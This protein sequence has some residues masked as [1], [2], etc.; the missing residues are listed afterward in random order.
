M[1]LLRENGYILVH[2]GMYQYENDIPVYTG[3]YQYILVYIG[4][5]PIYNYLPYRVYT[6]DIGVVKWYDNYGQK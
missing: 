6:F 3:I 1:I 2:T 4:M 5:Y